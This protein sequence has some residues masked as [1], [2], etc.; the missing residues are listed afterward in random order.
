MLYNQ[1]WIPPVIDCE[2]ACLLNR[3]ADALEEYG[4]AKSCLRN[5]NGNMCL[6]GAIMYAQ[7]IE[8]NNATPN[9]ISTTAALA[10]IEKTANYMAANIDFKKCHTL[11]L[12]PVGWNDMFETSS[13]QVIGALRQAAVI[14]NA[15]S[16]GS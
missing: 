4:H 15:E 7:G 8:L 1:D 2:M 6:V 12:S 13:Y 9:S 14:A 10:M 11:V 5:A 16:Q 3:A